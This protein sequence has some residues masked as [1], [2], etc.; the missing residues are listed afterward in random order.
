MSGNILEIRDL[1][2]D[3]TTER[4]A[5]QAVRQAS[6]DVPT[7]SIVG[8]VGE[9]GCGKSTIAAAIIQLLA[10][11]AVMK[12]G[13]ISF[14]GKNVL[15]L[16][17]SELRSLRGSEISMIFQDP[18]TALNPVLTIEQQMMDIQYRSSASKQNKREHI[19]EMLTRVGIPDPESRLQ[20]YPYEFSGGM[21]QRICIA[22][23]L[24]A[25]P[26]L[27]I[28]DEPTTA[29]DVTLEAQIV[30]LL[31]QLQQDINCSIVCVSHHLGM[32]SEL[33]QYVVV[34]YAGEVVE[35][36]TVRDIFHRA[37]H[38]YT[39][40]LLECDPANIKEARRDLPTIKGDLPDLYHPPQAC[41]F[42]ERCPKT[43]DICRTKRPERLRL[44]ERHQ[45]LCH[46]IN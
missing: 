34:M 36:G 18:M 16:S 17:T 15:N 46:H 30:S 42:F 12:G 41:I 7:A 1:S 23:A 26:K 13:L 31:K 29:L 24:M 38:P 2:I 6:L 5:L 22:M 21:R 40:L 8:L 39:Q 28:A 14:N 4:G 19:I 35:E 11:N 10:H 3:F 37:G 44:G 9:S 20:C 32:I 33:C 25:K 43:K 27:L 45:V